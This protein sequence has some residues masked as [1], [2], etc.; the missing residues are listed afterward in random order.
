MFV[1]LDEDDSELLESEELD[2][3]IE[4]GAVPDEPSALKSLRRHIEEKDGM[5]A[6]DFE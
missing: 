6:E 5:V 2:E 4:R 3:L 1:K